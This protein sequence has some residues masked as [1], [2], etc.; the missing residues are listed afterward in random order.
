MPTF[1]P[2]NWTDGAAPALTAAQL[3]RIESGVD[4]L[5]DARMPDARQAWLPSGAVAATMNRIEQ[6][7]GDMDSCLE[8]GRLALCGGT[9]LKGGQTVSSISFL[10]GVTGAT[11][12]TNC[13][14]C[15]V[16][17][18]TRAVLAKTNDA[19][20]LAWDAASVRTLFLTAPYT[21]SDDKAIYLGIVVVA[22]T[23]PSL[24]GYATSYSWA[25]A[26]GEPY[27]SCYADTGL[28][29]PASLGATT[30]AFNA[31]TA[32]ALAWVS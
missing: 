8:S 4:D 31:D 2:T 30:A 7:D 23:P 16:D 3:N 10:S 29:T 5:Y 26:I 28:T 6:G 24:R 18:S 21:P 13:W 15:L 22:A 12:P 14:Y 25:L 27:L 32:T 17:P 1:N 11:T 9:S 20:T 19:G